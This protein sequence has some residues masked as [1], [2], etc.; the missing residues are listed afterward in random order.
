[1]D[2]DERDLLEQ[3]NEFLSNKKRPAAIVKNVREGSS[4]SV[5][6]RQRVKEDLPGTRIPLDLASEASCAPISS[7]TSGAIINDIVERNPDQSE[8]HFEMPI[9]NTNAAVRSKRIDWRNKSNNS[10]A[11]SRFAAHR[12]ST[13]NVPGPDNIVALQNLVAVENDRKIASMTDSELLAE[14]N[15]LLST[16]DPALLAVLEK[17]RNREEA[18]SASTAEPDFGPLF[19]SERIS[20]IPVVKSSKEPKSPA[21]TR[22]STSNLLEGLLA[23]NMARNAHE[24]TSE[25]EALQD[26][27]GASHVHTNECLPSLEQDAIVPHVH[28]PSGPEFEELD[29]SS[30]TFLEDLK[31]KY[32]PTL[33]HDPS[34]LAWMRTPSV[35]E[36]VADYHE[37]NTSLMPAQIRFDFKGNFLAPRTSREVHSDLGLHH[38]ADAPLAAGYTIPE[39]AH[40]CRSSFPT[41]ACIAI[42]TIGRVMYKIGKKFYGES[43]SGKLRHLIEKSMVEK[44][45]LERSCDKH[46]SI[47]SYATEALWQANLGREGQIIEGQ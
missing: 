22:S 32:F 7:A 39:L 21:E 27:Q 13:E 42:Q 29:P 1:M 14:R 44:T 15:E 41:Q 28:F 45:L 40:L 18:V 6:D 34:S 25:V 16:L 35:A 10:K 4:S 9:S 8:D 47:S 37:S 17:R 2:P 26:N 20:S 3:Q 33:Q 5:K 24:Y 12:K 38:H 11:Q 46:L 30:E 19:T 23:A 43:I 31:T 36:D